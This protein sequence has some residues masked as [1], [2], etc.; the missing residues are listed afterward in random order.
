MTD[1]CHS[2]DIVCICIARAWC[3]AFCWV[4][5]LMFFKSVSK[6]TSGFEIKLCHDNFKKSQF[7]DERLLSHI[8][9]IGPL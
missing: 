8:L 1:S 6:G 2:N 9:K 4:C 3:G 5:I 7:M